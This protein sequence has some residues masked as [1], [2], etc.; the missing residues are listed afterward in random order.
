[1]ETRLPGFSNL[2]ARRVRATAFASISVVWC[3]SI[4]RAGGSRLGLALPRDRR[5]KTISRRTL[6]QMMG[7][8]AGALV[9]GT[10]NA[11]DFVEG[12][13]ASASAPWGGDCRISGHSTC[14]TT[15]TPSWYAIGALL[16]LCVRHTGRPSLP[17][18]SLQGEF[19]ARRF[20]QSTFGLCVCC[21]FC[22][23]R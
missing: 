21:A 1:M 2:L 6:M 3:D 12:P 10:T 22:L 4:S 18:V 20:R 23:H 16:S 8:G 14:L 7:A 5:M 11:R 9:V 19:T 13:E 17:C 15:S